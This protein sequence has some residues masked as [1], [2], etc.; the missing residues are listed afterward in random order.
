M[1]SFRCSQDLLPQASSFGPSLS[2]SQD[3]R[4]Q[5]NRPNKK[6]YEEEMEELQKLIR[7][8]EAEIKTSGN[9][10]P[11]ASP[12]QPRELRAEKE[13]A[14]NKRKK[15]DNDLRLLNEEIKK[16]MGQLSKTESNLH[17]KNE[18]KIDD[19]IRKMEWQL[20]TQNFRLSE[21]RKIV[22]EVDKLK[23]SKKVLAEYFTQKKEV[24]KMRESQRR[25]RGEREYYYKAVTNI[26]K[27][28]EELKKANHEKKVKIEEIKKELDQ[29]YNKKRELFMEFKQC[30]SDYQQQLKERRHWLRKQS[31]K[32]KEEERK[33]K[34]EIWQKEMMEYEAQREPFEDEKNLC[35]T[36]ISYLQ[37][38]NNSEREDS[39]LS[40]PREER[41]DLSAGIGLADSL[42]GGKYV[43]LKKSEEAEVDYSVA[44][45]PR[46]RSKKGRK[47]SVTKPLAH[48]P[49]I[50][51]QFS[52]LNL[53]APSNMSELAAS[54]EQLQARKRYYEE[55]TGHV[56]RPLLGSLS[57]SFS[58][59]G[60]LSSSL[61]SPL[62][63]R[64]STWGF[65]EVPPAIAE[66]Q[67]PSDAGNSA[68]SGFHDMSRQASKTESSESTAEC[69]QND[70]A[71]EELI[72][73]STEYG[74][75]ET[76]RSS[77]DTITPEEHIC[78]DQSK[79][80]GSPKSS[81][82]NIESVSDNQSL[83]S[84]DNDSAESLVFE[85]NAKSNLLNEEYLR[86][87]NAE[88]IINARNYDTDF[89]PAL[90]SDIADREVLSDKLNCDVVKD[91][92]LNQEHG[93][94]WKQEPG[95]ESGAKPKD[96]FV[97]GGEN[98]VIPGEQS[99]DDSQ[100][101]NNVL[102]VGSGSDIDKTSGIEA[103]IEAGIVTDGSNSVVQT[104]SETTSDN[105]N[106]GE[107]VGETEDEVT[108]L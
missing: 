45:K 3:L 6:K 33:A 95:S 77:S 71:L 82:G 62:R 44:N 53:N 65:V 35:N 58:S 102:E 74:E 54:I 106:T 32:K 101:D 76:S 43:L 79:G 27:R 107:E 4:R 23:R 16:K 29:L 25:M 104:I 42:D 60:S 84:H 41:P 47:L 81:Q 34:E 10:N 89:P 18:A 30:E 59:S 57:G 67:T 83:H 90:K 12:V 96:K 31:F 24:D 20:K 80:S 8:K 108:H 87:I 94:A 39:M 69:A 9:A 14:I 46:R 78:E 63:D 75:S 11:D 103:G 64:S 28:E 68:E 1:I 61:D 5:M 105:N 55:E 49:Q 51:A 19:A 70:Q 22:A 100:C 73:Q 85:E 72:K 92:N 66:N 36:L 93:N 26:S 38:R 98:V 15:L 50:I 91:K 21:E 13:A 37:K 97:S 56:A 40:S 2:S 88:G 17:Y 52:S 48:T 7:A 99:C 86:G